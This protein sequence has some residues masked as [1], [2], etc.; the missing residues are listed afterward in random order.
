MNP[1][2]IKKL[3]DFAVSLRSEI[4]QRQI[5]LEGAEALLKIATDGYKSDQ[6]F[7]E[8]EVQKKKDEVSEQV[9]SLQTELAKVTQEKEA[10]LSE[11]AVVDVTKLDTTLSEPSSEMKPQAL[12]E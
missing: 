4:T 2:Q 9:A 6:S 12:P 7:I 11:I 10:I 8:E 1:K 3:E 5:L